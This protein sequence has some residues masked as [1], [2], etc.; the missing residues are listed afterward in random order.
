MQSRAMQ[1][2]FFNTEFDLRYQ[3]LRVT[4]F[5]K[6]QIYVQMPIERNHLK[7]LNFH[8]HCHL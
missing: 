1:F 5:V 7:R 2:S 8:Y 3:K 6:L 4:H